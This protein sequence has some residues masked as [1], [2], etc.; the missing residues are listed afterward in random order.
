MA[1]LQ[2]HFEL[3]GWAETT[4]VVRFWLISALCVATGLA[5]VLHRMDARIDDRA[6]DRPRSASRASACPGRAAARVLAARGAR[7]T[8]VDAR[9]DEAL[10]A[11]AAGCPASTVRLGDGD[12]LPPG[13]D[14]VRHLAGLAARRAAARRRGRGRDRDHR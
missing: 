2:H 4:I 6:M 10:R 11:Q 5:P 7:V 3:S 14:L 12:T 13:T 8:V 1:P 9:D